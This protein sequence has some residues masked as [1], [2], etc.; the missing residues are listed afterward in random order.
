[1]TIQDAHD[2]APLD[3]PACP[4]R[5]ILEAVALERPELEASVPPSRCDSPSAAAIAAVV[6]LHQ[7]GEL[8]W[9]DVHRL[10]HVAETTCRR[11]A[12]RHGELMRTHRG[13]AAICERIVTRCVE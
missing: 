13:Y 11:F 8:S 3:E 4:A 10:T 6:L 12:Q 7:L 5:R 9:G 2:P 1:M